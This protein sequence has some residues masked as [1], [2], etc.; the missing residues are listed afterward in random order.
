M[1][2]NTKEKANI[3]PR[4]HGATT[5]SLLGA[6][7]GKMPYMV[8]LSRCVRCGQDIFVGIRKNDWLL[9][10]FWKRAEEER[11][12]GKTIESSCEKCEKSGWRR[13]KRLP[14]HEVLVDLR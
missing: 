5:K 14:A 7:V 8:V 9:Q 10:R 3:S 11:R 13:F 12:Q 4:V 6:E 1:N 2:G